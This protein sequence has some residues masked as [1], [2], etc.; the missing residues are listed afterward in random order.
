[1][2]KTKILR[3][4]RHHDWDVR[5]QQRLQRPGYRRSRQMPPLAPSPSRSPLCTGTFAYFR[6]HAE[7]ALLFQVR[8]ASV[9]LRV[10]SQI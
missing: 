9:G 10:W 6:R 8:L 4:H 1:M 3:K 2:H 7:A 5:L